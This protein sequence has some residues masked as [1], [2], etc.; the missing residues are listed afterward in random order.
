MNSK[1]ISFAIALLFAAAGCT[2]PSSTPDKPAH[3]VTGAP[4]KTGDVTKGFPVN[5]TP[6]QVIRQYWQP[7]S[8]VVQVGTGGGSTLV[9]LTPRLSEVYIHDVPYT[10]DLPGWG[11]TSCLDYKCGSSGKGKSELWN[12]FY[13]AKGEDKP[14]ALAKAIDGIGKSSAKGLIESKVFQSKPKSWT[15]FRT[16]MNKA[17][18]GDYITQQ[19]YNEVFGTY[20][21]VNRANLGY[22]EADCQAFTTTCEVYGMFPVVNG[23]SQKQQDERVV[24]HRNVPVQVVVS[25]PF[26]QSFETDNLTVSAGG[27]FDSIQVTGGQYTNYQASKTPTGDGAII[28]VNGMSRRMVDVP[29]G[30]FKKISFADQRGQNLQYTVEVDPRYLGQGEDKLMMKIEVRHCAS[31]G[32]FSFQAG[33]CKGKDKE[34]MVYEPMQTIQLTQASTNMPITAIPVGHRVWVKYTLSRENSPWY[35]NTP[36]YSN[37]EKMWDLK[38]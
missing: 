36:F 31:G 34:A 1:R 10:C 14:A 37:E 25:N 16:A 26:L 32:L 35:N 7:D 13:S 17:L 21:E 6:S 22:A 8:S 11:T 3:T 20:G 38:K 18:K 19:Q 2:T 5:R 12:A 33:D 15:E 9:A 24:S 27:D 23:C 30:A 4:L 29:R 28:T